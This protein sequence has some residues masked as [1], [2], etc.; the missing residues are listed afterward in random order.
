MFSLNFVV[1]QDNIQFV[2]VRPDA[3]SITDYRDSLEEA[4]TEVQRLVNEWI[5]ENNWYH[6]R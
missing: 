1:N 6:S 5:K 3:T 2:L 4:F